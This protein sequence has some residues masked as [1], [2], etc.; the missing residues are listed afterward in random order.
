MQI[1]ADNLA[2]ER[3]GR[4]V[5]SQVSFRLSS[6]EFLQLTGPNGAG[7]SSLLRLLAGLNVATAGSIAVSEGAADLSLGE[8]AHYI[9]H[10]D[11]SKAA[12]TVRENLEFWRDVLGGG[13]LDQALSAVNL[14]AL[15]EYPAGLLSQG[16]RR[17]LALARIALVDRP[18][19][20][21]D[22]PSVGLDE[23]SRTLLTRLMQRHLAAQ[24]LIIATTHVPLGL[25]PDRSLT[26]PGVQRA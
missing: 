13:D 26:L 2:C 8:Q 1:T 18:V 7:K 22:E 4:Q 24:G 23:N 11:S 25:E 14:G 21:L 17:R 15:R 19:W 6:G 10:S 16:Q 12:L 5:F 3:G 9:A 20:L